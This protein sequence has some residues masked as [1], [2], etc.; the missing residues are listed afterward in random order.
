MHCVEFASASVRAQSGHVVRG[1]HVEIR[2]QRL[3]LQWLLV[4][5]SKI[6]F[7]SGV[8]GIRAAA[9]DWILTK[10]MQSRASNQTI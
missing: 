6:E 10:A 7:F 9:H 2:L 1:A 8:C 5:E 4:Q 3:D